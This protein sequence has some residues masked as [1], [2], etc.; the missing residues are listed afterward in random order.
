MI[1]QTIAIFRRSV[2][3]QRREAYAVRMLAGSSILIDGH[4]IS[5]RLSVYGSWRGLLCAG[6][7]RITP[8]WHDSEN[9]GITC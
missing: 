7:V 8:I 2:R 3:S 5:D 4:V 9:R 1:K 6:Y